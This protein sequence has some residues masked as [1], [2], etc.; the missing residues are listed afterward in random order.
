[1]SSTASALEDRLARYRPILD[2]AIAERNA[3]ASMRE[4]LAGSDLVELDRQPVESGRSSNRSRVLVGATAA[5]MIGGLAVVVAARDTR[6]VSPARSSPVD[7]E[8]TNEGTAPSATVVD[9]TPA[10]ALAGSGL[11]PACPVGA[12]TIGVGTLY[13]GGPAS[14]QNLAAPGFIFSL[15]AGP[16][17]VDVAIDAIGLPVIGQ[18]CSITAAPT[19]DGSTV[20]VTVD[21]P[22]VPTSLRFDVRVGERDGVIGVTGITG[23]T[24]F[25]TNRV[26]DRA[27]LTLKGGV[28]ASATRIQV[29]FKKGDDVWELTTDPTAGTVVDLA[30]PNGETDRFPDQAVDWV[31]FTA[32]DATEHV[33]DAGGGII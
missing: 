33:V 22:A 28:P 26:G 9:T 12:D 20:T 13:L 23:S 15:P 6:P 29:R 21:P 18:Q 1:M 14:D 24:S 8:A 16:A 30:V 19:A 7:S 2:G 3:V 10:T 5:V 11:T 32:I 31:L 25:E 17:P 4:P 27:T